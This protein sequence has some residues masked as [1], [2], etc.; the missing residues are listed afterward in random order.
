[1]VRGVCCLNIVD[2]VIIGLL[3]LGVVGGYSRGF[4]ASLINLVGSLVGLIVAA[5]Y[6]QDMVQWLNASFSLQA[7]L[8][9][10]FQD[11]LAIP[12]PIGQLKLGKIPVAELSNH[13]EKLNIPAQFKLQLFDYLQTLDKV[14]F[15]Q[16]KDSLDQIIQ[17]FLASEIGRAH[18]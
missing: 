16:G 11:N 12:L 10:V 14:T 17:Q 5:K 6:Y 9:Q 8:D 2:I 3:L 18:V 13:L 7:K 15:L 1:M 4:F